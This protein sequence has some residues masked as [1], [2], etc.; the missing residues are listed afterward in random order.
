MTTQPQT[1]TSKPD[2][3]RLPFVCFPGAALCCCFFFSSF[4]FFPVL[5]Q[6]AIR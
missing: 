2:S 4:V 5:T 1:N 6:Q 3:Q